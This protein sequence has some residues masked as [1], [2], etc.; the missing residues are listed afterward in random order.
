MTHGMDNLAWLATFWLVVARVGGIFLLTP[1]FAS[2]AVPVKLRAAMSV[3]I[4]LAVAGRAASPAACATT[5]QFAAACGLEFALGAT[6]GLVA[7]LV[8]A[9]VELGAAHVGQQ[10][11]VA[12]ADVI[13]PSLEASGVVRG[14]YLMLAAAVFLTIGGHRQVIAALLRTF[15]AIPVGGFAP[16]AALTGAATAVL[17]AAVL[18]ALKLAAPVL[19]AMLLATVAMGLVQKTV[20]QCHLLSVGLPL[21]A[22]LGLLVIAVT[23]AAT[24]PLLSAAVEGAMGQLNAAL[25]AR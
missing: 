1:V 3:A 23:V 10:M 11:G 25:S 13:D 9:G 14:L 7:R 24:A 5:A 17:G 16:G 15:D 20:P 4:A 19:V 18:L 2:Q 21:R 22:M 8:F 12:L 6:I